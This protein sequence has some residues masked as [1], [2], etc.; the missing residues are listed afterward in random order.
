MHQQA[1]CLHRGLVQN[2]IPMILVLYKTRWQRLP[3]SDD[4]MG[5]MLLAET[6]MDASV[7]AA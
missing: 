4:L 3:V 6:L 7:S 5:A 1:Y 2:C